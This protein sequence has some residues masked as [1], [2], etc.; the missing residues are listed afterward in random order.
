MVSHKR[1]Y[2]SRL[3]CGERW[4]SL[5]NV[6]ATIS[7]SR[8]K[9]ICSSMSICLSSKGTPMCSSSRGMSSLQKVNPN[10][11]YHHVFLLGVTHHSPQLQAVHTDADLM[12]PFLQLELLM[13]QM[14][15]FQLF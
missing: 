13:D 4:W 9:Y 8:G 1:D 5:L 3:G 11:C 2:C 7:S 12:V 10:T 15:L 6:I 14:A